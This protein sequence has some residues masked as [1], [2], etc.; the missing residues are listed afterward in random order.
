METKLTDLC[1]IKHNFLTE[2]ECDFLIEYHKNNIDRRLTELSTNVFDGI[3]RE[4]SFEMV[5]VFSKTDPIAILSI[6]N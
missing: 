1:F 3:K 4:A 2:K 5:E 6:K